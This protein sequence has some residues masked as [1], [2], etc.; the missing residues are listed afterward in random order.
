M[1]ALWLGAIL[2]LG[3]CLRVAQVGESLWLDEL[4]T[5][6]TVSDSWS[7]VAPRTRMGNNSPLYF[8]LPW[9]TARAFGLTEV[10][11]RLPSLLAGTAL[12]GVIYLVVH[13][14]TGH[15]GMALMAAALAAMDRHFL[16]YS[17]E[18]RP[19]VFVQTLGVVHVATFWHLVRR[20]SATIRAVWIVGAIVLFY[21]HYT[22][23][24]LIPAEVVYYLVARLGWRERLRYRGTSLLLDVT[25]VLIAFLPAWNH[26]LWVASRRE[27]WQLFV[28]QRPLGAV[29]RVFPLT[30]YVALP[31]IAA[32]VVGLV[33][34]I[35]K[36]PP[37]LA[38]IDFRLLLLVIG[39]LFV[40]LVLAWLTTWTDVARLLFRRYV[41]VVSVAPLVLAALIGSLC[42]SRAARI[43]VAALLVGVSSYWIGPIPQLLRDGRFVNH[44]DEDWRRAVQTL[45]REAARRELPVLVYSGL[46]E[47][48]ALRGADPVPHDPLREYCLF[49]V[50][51]I[52]SMPESPPPLVPLP[53]T[54]AGVLN[55]RQWRMV[56]RARGVW[57][58]I[59]G[60]RMSIDRMLR[61][62]RESAAEND[63]NVTIARRQEFV[64]PTD[65]LGWRAWT[66]GAESAEEGPGNARR[67]TVTLVRLELATSRDRISR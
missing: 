61:Q 51:G 35:R 37:Y 44:G 25:L 3:L 26:L 59:R 32:A 56:L 58:L 41:M 22:A 13:A 27:S 38:T 49:P 12:I 17:L 62:L 9:M 31:L 47:A 55:Q 67:S 43:G 20:P 10:A 45:R 16:F 46:I 42:P 8:Y 7:D 11:L 23:A 39:W 65:P 4:H 63:L 1:A 33:R 66:V 2:T 64:R 57:L 36:R 28:A 18:A 21:L 40:P 29:F 14:W 24:L 19:Y 50:R 30:L 60:D 15:R 6:W 5:A 34:R 53:T 52:Y 48:D 54:Q